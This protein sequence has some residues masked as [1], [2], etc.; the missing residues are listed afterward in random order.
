[1][2]LF[3]NKGKDS[4]KE[5]DEMRRALGRTERPKET[6]TVGQ[7]P[8]GDAG[9][10]GD[11]AASAASL[12]TTSPNQ[13]TQAVPAD[14]EKY[15]SVVSAGS[16]WRGTLKLEGS[17]RVEGHL[18]GEIE[19][20]DTVYV[21]EGAHVDAQVQAAYVVIAGTFEGQVQCS[22]RLELMP[23]S[24]ITGDMTTK[25]LM[26]HEGAFID[27]QIHMTNDPRSGDPAKRVSG[28]S[29][30]TTKPAASDQPEPV[31]VAS[32]ESDRP[33]DP[34]RAPDRR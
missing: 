23:T 31:P 29:V 19:A 33:A 32:A 24:R 2:S 21:A 1:M 16:D 4:T 28:A 12:S 27:G 22:E 20:R 34:A 9:H 11:P 7:G 30:K 26:I 25:A 18:S 6:D 10:S 8:V 17:V 5:F 13:P 14:P 15:S 3:G